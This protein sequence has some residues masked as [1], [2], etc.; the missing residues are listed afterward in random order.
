MNYR[1]GLGMTQ[2]HIENAASLDGE[3]FE[4]VP[5]QMCKHV[6]NLTVRK[7]DTSPHLMEHILRFDI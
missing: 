5:L 2:R 4:W 1:T 3:Y 7:Q 6:N